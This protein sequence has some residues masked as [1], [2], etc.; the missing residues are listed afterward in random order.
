MVCVHADLGLVMWLLEI[1]DFAL[2]ES[3]GSGGGV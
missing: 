3:E 1:C 2:L